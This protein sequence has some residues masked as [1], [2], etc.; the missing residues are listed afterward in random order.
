MAETASA[1]EGF[2]GNKYQRKIAASRGFSGATS[3]N[4][5]SSSVNASTMNVGSS[6]RYDNDVCN[7]LNTSAITSILN[8]E[9]DAFSMSSEGDAINARRRP[10]SEQPADIQQSARKLSHL[11]VKDSEA[12][13]H[14]QRQDSSIGNQISASNKLATKVFDDDGVTMTHRVIKPLE[15]SEPSA[16]PDLI[17]VS[18]SMIASVPQ[19][20]HDAAE[21]H[22]EPSLSESYHIPVQS[23]QD[24]AQFISHDTPD[25]Q[26]LVV[27]TLVESNRDIYGTDVIVDAIVIDDKPIDDKPTPFY[28]RTLL[29]LG[30]LVVAAVAV[31]GVVTALIFGESNGTET[32]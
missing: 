31:T 19:H 28:P 7:I 16:S 4:E 22:N 32:V 24:N 18:H 11:S 10:K 3:N 27:A 1:D 6:S 30:I 21:E 8:S 26:G 14:R 13:E 23:S 15:N 20:L 2:K 9:P 12:R 17:D 29:M 25:T 5:I